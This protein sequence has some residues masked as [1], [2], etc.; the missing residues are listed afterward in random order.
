MS[1]LAAA[2][3]ALLLVFAVLA[4]PLLA[5]LTGLAWNISGAVRDIRDEVRRMSVHLDE[6]LEALLAQ[7]LPS[8]GDQS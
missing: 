1:I 5:T 8:R 6:A 3:E 4:V 7:R 2:L